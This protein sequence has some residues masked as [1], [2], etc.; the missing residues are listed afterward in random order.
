MSE[1]REWQTGRTVLLQWQ[2]VRPEVR[3]DRS[4]GRTVRNE[5][6][7][8]QRPDLSKWDTCLRSDWIA[9]QFATLVPRREFASPAFRSLTS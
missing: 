1:S 7:I 4:T 2:R 8:G 5:M 9:K 3:A 6:R